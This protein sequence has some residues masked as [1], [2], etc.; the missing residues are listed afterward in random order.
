[1]KKL[2]SFIL[3][4]VMLTCAASAALAYSPEEPITILF[5]HTRGSGANNAALLNLVNT[6]NETV[7][8]EK[9]IV[10]EEVF[11]GDYHNLHAKTQLSTQTDEQPVIAVSGCT[12]YYDLALD[13]LTVN[14]AELAK[15]TGFDRNN[16]LDC[17]L[18]TP[19]NQNEDELYGIP[20]IRSTPVL[21]YNKTLADEKGLSLPD[22]PTVDEWIEFSRKMHTVD[23]NNEVATWGTTILG[24]FSYIGTAFPR[25]M[26]EPLIADDCSGSPA[27]DGTALLKT[28]SAWRSWV[29]EGFYRP[30]DAT[31][32][33]YS[34]ELFYQGKLGSLITSSG[35]AGNI[36][37]TLAQNGYEL[38]VVGYPTFDKD[39]P[40]T[41]I[42][43]GNL[44]LIQKGNTDE[45]IR[46]GWEFIQFAMTDAMVLA[47]TQTTG[48][49]PVTKSVASY[50]PML[51]FWAENPAHYTAYQQL[52]W[53]VC[54][55]WP[56][57]DLLG[58]V[59]AS[60]NKVYSLLIQEQSITAEEAVEQFKLE[61]ESVF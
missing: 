17:F 36:T 6:F 54:Q 48:Y 38:R 22:F 49:V 45:Q 18:N 32:T 41:E 25:Q 30:Q 33:A 42:G 43:G 37:K 28:F 29:D 7:G 46:A 12:Y 51:D 2:F 8:K 14:M 57:F 60:I 27:A 56:T 53:G 52:A 10:V 34:M 16:L 4:L 58:D 3:A 23:A 59:N 50:Q 61:M 9:G 11:I 35:S 40:S 31:G 20:Y 55:E 47:E 19:G 26:G 15:E 13:G 24:N 44:V 1:M 21:Y 5:W 39:N